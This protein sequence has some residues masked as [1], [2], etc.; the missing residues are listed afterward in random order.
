IL[1]AW[2]G[3]SSRPA[4]LLLKSGGEKAESRKQKAD[5]TWEDRDLDHGDLHCFLLSALCFLL[6]ALSPTP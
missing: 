6:T 1:G 5:K 2:M 3:H 4:W